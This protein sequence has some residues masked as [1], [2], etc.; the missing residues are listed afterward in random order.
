MSPVLSDVFVATC[1][2]EIRVAVEGFGG[3][4]IM[5]SAAHE[6]GTDRIAEA[7]AT[8]GL[9]DNDIAV[10]VQGDEPLLHPDML[11]LAVRPLLEDDR[12]HCTNLM[13]LIDSD[14]EHQS[15]DE[16][17]VVADSAGFAMYMSRA[18][19]P[20][21]TRRVGA[22]PRYKQVCVIGFRYGVL[23]KF[24]AL[25]QSPLE[26]VES[27]DMLRLMENGV[28]V[29]LVES[30]FKTQAVDTPAGLRVVEE[31]MRGDAILPRYAREG[32]RVA[33]T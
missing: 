4:A 32:D 11:E 29:R 8:L 2:H 14:A 16:I 25:P 19:I 23:R 7:A 9:G 21:D 30:A 5:T 13:T 24:V 17:K 20:T 3:Q 31:L 18:A 15:T 1:D 22:G 26:R 6:R 10:N 27:I 28:P 12:L 33:R